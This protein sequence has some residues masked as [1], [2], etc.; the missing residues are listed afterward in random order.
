L[1][2]VG[3]FDSGLGGLSVLRAVREALPGDDL[4]YAADSAYAPYGDQ[5]DDYIIDRSNTVADFLLAHGADA[6]VVACNTATAV[7]IETLRARLAIPVIGIEPGVKPAVA[8]T[9]SGVVGVMTTSATAAA[10]KFRA[11][12]ERHHGSARVIVQPCPGLVEQ[13]EKGDLESPATRALVAGYVEPLVADGADVIVLGCT[14]YPFLKP[15]VQDVAGPACV[16]IDPSAAVASQVVRRL[17]ANMAPAAARPGTVAFWTT[18][19]P[20]RVRGL[21]EHLSGGAVDLRR[22]PDPVR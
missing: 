20:E 11:L 6:L 22:M 2:V 17:H 1:A 3:V 12:V 15:V 16:L 14:H 8:A 18:G 19:E 9:K 5:A 21:I 10:P 13:V 7:A 4:I